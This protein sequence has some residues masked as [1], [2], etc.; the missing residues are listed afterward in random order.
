MKELREL[1]D[2]T[3]DCIRYHK[4]GSDDDTLTVIVA[5]HI[6]AGFIGAILL[7]A[8][9]PI[10]AWVVI[11]AVLALIFGIIWQF[12]PEGDLSVGY[13]V[14]FHIS[15]MAWVGV[16]PIALF[17]GIFTFPII[18]HEYK[19]SHPKPQPEKTEQIFMSDEAIEVGNKGKKRKKK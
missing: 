10:G 11:G 8:L 19:E 1:I 3:W 16:L 9:T 18:I 14:A 15:S 7:A 6:L 4:N 5:F 12:C 13:F 2:E 17:I